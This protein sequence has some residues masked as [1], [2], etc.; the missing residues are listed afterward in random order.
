VKAV[1]G[2]TVAATGITGGGG[3][4]GGTRSLYGFFMSSFFLSEILKPGIT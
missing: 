4:G 1:V 2:G 3:G